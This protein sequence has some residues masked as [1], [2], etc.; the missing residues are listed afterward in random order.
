M[1]NVGGWG[2]LEVNDFMFVLHSLL[3]LFHVGAV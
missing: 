2:P 1:L 3:K